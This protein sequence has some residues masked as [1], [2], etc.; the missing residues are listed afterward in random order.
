MSTPTKLVKAGRRATDPVV[1]ANVVHP[2]TPSEKKA[3]KLMMR[4]ASPFALGD[5]MKADQ[6]AVQGVDTPPAG[7][8]QSV[9]DG[10]I[11]TDSTTGETKMTTE[12]PKV[13]DR[14]AEAAKDAENAAHNAKLKQEKADAA[15]KAKAEKTEAAAK[16]K[17]ER[18]AKLETERQAKAKAKEERDAAASAKKAERDAERAK[19]VEGTDRKYTGTMLALAERV[20][21]GAYVKSMTG[22]LRSN[23]E[24]A[25]A[26]DA[27]PPSNVVKLAMEVLGVD[28]NPYEHLNIGQQSMNFR[29]KLRGAI[30]K[31]VEVKGVKVTL[32]RVKEVRDANNYATAEDEATK[33]AEKKAAREK[34]LAEKKAARE[35]AEADNKAAKEKALREKA[36]AVTGAV[37][38]ANAAKQEQAPAA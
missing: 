9:S 1:P 5:N 27:V 32:D 22:Q 7:V 29:N 6:D 13:R 10:K 11:A 2:A 33:R 30:R 19:L 14:A 3:A 12:A 24:L 37:A 31:E 20:R 16:T 38:K 36:E 35:K 21:S 4:G 23:D 28:V 18:D 26:L 17:A 8:V 25:Q 34:A 15:A